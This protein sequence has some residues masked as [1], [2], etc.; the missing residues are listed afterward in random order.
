[1]IVGGWTIRPTLH[2]GELLSSYLLRC[3]HAHGS[4]PYRF[5]HLFWPGRAIWNRDLDRDPDES[6]LADLSAA[7]GVSLDRLRD[8]ALI[9]L[10]S[11]L[12]ARPRRHGDSRFVLSAGVYHRTRRRHAMQYCPECLLQTDDP[13][14]RRQW[15]LAFVV[16]CEEHDIRLSDACPGCDAPVIPHRTMPGF[17]G[18]CHACGRGLGESATRDPARHVSKSVAQLQST[19]L[20][21]L[22]SP[23]TTTLLGCKSASDAF[24]VLRELVGIVLEEERFHGS[25]TGVTHAA[26]WATP[27]ER[28]AFERLRLNDRI[29]ILRLIE[30]WVRHWPDGFRERACAMRLTRRR[31]LGRKWPESLEIEIARLP[32]GV[33]RKRSG[34]PPLHDCDLRSLRRHEPFRYRQARAERLMRLAGRTGP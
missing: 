6:W 25:E 15:R 8:A 5:L 13:W 14:W 22:G 26:G 4:T 30:P 11:G 33:A 17:A 16:S 32:E 7:S 10:R 31:F 1:M 21:V 9:G 29:R 12:D 18:R 3:A 2:E 20:T 27:V 19:L 24:A 23:A 34:V 28:R